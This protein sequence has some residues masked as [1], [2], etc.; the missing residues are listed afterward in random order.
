MVSINISIKKEAYEFLKSLSKG[1]KSF[2]DVILEFKENKKSNKDAIMKHFGALKD[3]DLS[4]VE[5][6]M[7]EFRDNFEKRLNKRLK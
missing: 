6:N 5:N 1:E 3:Y 4:D 2:S 7:K